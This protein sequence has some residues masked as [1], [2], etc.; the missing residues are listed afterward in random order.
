MN[1]GLSIKDLNDFDTHLN[2]NSD[3]TGSRQSI[4]VITSGGMSDIFLW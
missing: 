3:F 4:S 2:L 1:F